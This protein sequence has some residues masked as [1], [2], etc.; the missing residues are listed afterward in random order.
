MKIHIQT[1]AGNQAVRDGTMPKAIEELVDKLQPEA[2]YFLPENGRRSAYL[3]FDLADPSR[4]PVVVEPLF[5][6]L[7]AEVEFTPV[8]NL[9][10]LQR[11]L[12]EIGTSH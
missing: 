3:F 10:D 7:A 5:E 11:G 8:M 9:T 2:A 1:E 12:S 6:N 4:I